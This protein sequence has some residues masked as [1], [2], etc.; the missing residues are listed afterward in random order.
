MCGDNLFF[1]GCQ[2]SRN[3]PEWSN[4]F[5]GRNAQQKELQSL[6]DEAK[7]GRGKFVVVTGEAGIGKT[8][9][10]KRFVAENQNEQ[11]S[12][13]FEDF[14]KA[15]IFEPYLPFIRIIDK[16]G[17]I[18]IASV[19]QEERRFETQP[20][21]EIESLYSLQSQHGLMQQKLLTFFLEA[22]KQKPLL[23]VFSNVH[24]AP[25]TSWKFIHY[26]GENLKQ[27]RILVVATLR[28]EGRV[29]RGGKLP[30]YADVLQR[31]NR[32]GLLHKIQLGRLSEKNI[33]RLLLAVFP[34]KDFS[35][36][37]FA[38]ISEISGGN[39]SLIIKLINRCLE[40]G[41]IFERED[42][43]FNRHDIEK[44]TLLKL[45]SD[46]SEISAGK[47][48]WK[49]LCEAQ[50]SLLQ[51]AVLLDSAFDHHIL[52]AVTGRS[53]VQILKDLVFLKD[54]N[55]LYESEDGKYSLKYPTLL[56]VIL[57]TIS[58]EEKQR[59]HQSIAR[60]IEASGFLSPSEKI[61]RLAYHYSQTDD[62]CAAFKY[63]RRASEISVEN[64][65]FMEA[66]EFL[67]KAL[68][69]R[70]ALPEDI[71]RGEIVQMLIWA[72]WLD[73]ILGYWDDSN[74][75]AEAALELLKGESDRRLKSQLLIQQGFTYFRL[76]DWYK[77]RD[78]F[79]RCLQDKQTLG[80]VDEAMAT[81][82]LGN[83]YFELTDYEKS[84][85]YFE[86]ALE[87]AD[88]LQDKQ[89]MAN[90]FNNLGALENIRSHRMKAIALYSKSIP[91][92]KSLGDNFGLARIYHNI[93]MT[94]AD[95]N[96]WQ[97]ANEF[98]G[99]SLIVSDVMGLVPLKSITFLNRAM[100]LVKLK[101]IDEARE[102]N[103]KAFRLLEQLKDE[104]GVAEFH[105]IQGVIERE[106]GNFAM[107]EVEF[108]KA[109]EKFSANE[110]RLGVAESCYERALLFLNL[111]KQEAAVADLQKALEIYDGLQVT[112]KSEQIRRL[113]E[114]IAV[115]DQNA[116]QIIDGTEVSHEN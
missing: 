35:S 8:A 88:K 87:F 26:L 97:R 91:L 38:W 55:I 56:S 90:V 24:L 105:K 14:G 93:G 113:L 86:K 94:Y 13:I 67:E 99:Q 95:E 96:N 101:K 50:K 11:I 46:K 98:Y 39:P 85:K 30:V 63:L 53:R 19:L 33:R 75:H 68:S 3:I 92:F 81:Y 23:M 21:F 116:V 16:L 36:Q 62:V 54:N 20:S 100:A 49:S 71:E 41:I 107:S 83:V 28:Q 64:F 9:L 61:F 111:Q 76:N 65:A 47:K 44:D 114:E 112:E 4:A 73:R 18:G 48:L 37:F 32:E 40:T 45:V 103:F 6:L 110:N 22:A 51:F 70:N 5:A 84:S 52:C 17:Q 25:V 31:M 57:E 10:V 82:G 115:E 74:K 27:N 1:I 66:K 43:W 106:E 7:K 77:A 59:R 29:I 12:V 58:A 34:R 42:V 89:L 78:C 80:K 108:A 60:E 102:Y 69:L 72:C 79:E 109:I 15:Q 104:L 2:V